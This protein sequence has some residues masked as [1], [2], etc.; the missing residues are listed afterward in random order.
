MVYPYQ[1]LS[2]SRVTEATKLTSEDEIFTS[3]QLQFVSHLQDQVLNP[4]P[5]VV[6]GQ[7][8]TLLHHRAHRSTSP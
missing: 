4:D 5:P 7:C 2:L 1:P 6:T 8:Q 3:M